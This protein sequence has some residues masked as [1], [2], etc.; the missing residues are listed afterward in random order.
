MTWQ[1]RFLP[2]YQCV[3]SQRRIPSVFFPKFIFL[4]HFIGIFPLKMY[5]YLMCPFK[6]ISCKN[7]LGIFTFV[8]IFNHSPAQDLSNKK[9]ELSTSSVGRDIPPTV[10]QVLTHKHY[11]LCAHCICFARST[12]TSDRAIHHQLP[13]L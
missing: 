7:I 10:Y 9:T 3:M 4:K 13:S 11:T 8:K 1:K 5:T 2:Q 12:G 6:S